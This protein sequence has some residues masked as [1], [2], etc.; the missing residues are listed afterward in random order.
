MLGEKLKLL[1]NGK[2]IELTD[3]VIGVEINNEIETFE[4]KYT[5][6]FEGKIEHL[7]PAYF[8]YYKKTQGDKICKKNARYVFDSDIIEAINKQQKEKWERGEI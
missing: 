3:S 2:K 8:K 4:L 5:E 6:S 7:N 1:I